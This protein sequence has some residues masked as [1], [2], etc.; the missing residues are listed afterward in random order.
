MHYILPSHNAANFV[1]PLNSKVDSS[2]AESRLWCSGLL[3][4]NSGIGV[5]Q[6]N[7]YPRLAQRETWQLTHGPPR[8]HGVGALKGIARLHSAVS[9]LAQFTASVGKGNDVALMTAPPRPLV[10]GVPYVLVVY[11]LRWAT[12]RSR[13]AAA[14]RDAEL[15]LA[16]AGASTVAV[17]SQHTGRQLE[18]LIPDCGGRIRVIPLGPGHINGTRD[19]SGV[20][21]RVIL[22]G[23]A[24]HKR[25]DIAA[26]ALAIGR[27]PWAK[28]FMG[29]GIGDEAKKELERAFGKESCTWADVLSSQKLA[30][31]YET[32]ETYIGLSTSEGFGLPYLE[33]LASGCHVIAIDQPLTREVLGDAAILL[34]DGT[35][36]DIA[37]QLSSIA[38]SDHSA[39]ARHDKLLFYQWENTVCQL[40]MLLQAAIRDR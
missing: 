33:A 13:V 38:V 31:W 6:R 21:G 35:T 15:R 4:E 23:G 8:S 5:F 39:A 12:T 37:R 10:M 2:R 17:I 3:P 11:D 18:R 25:N 26:M 36:Q 20:P 22:L 24:P 34:R 27:P 29:V 14:Y 9:L 32:A 16:V 19:A 7:V 40:D 1:E 28:T 30:S